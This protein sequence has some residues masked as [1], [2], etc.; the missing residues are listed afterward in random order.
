MLPGCDEPESSLPRRGKAAVRRHPEDAGPGLV[1]GMCA[2]PAHDRN[3]GLGGRRVSSAGS[4]PARPSPN[5]A[6]TGARSSLSCSPPRHRSPRRGPARRR[7]YPPRRGRLDTPGP[8]RPRRDHLRRRHRR[9][10]PAANT[11]RVQYETAKAVAQRLTT[12]GH[13]LGNRRC[14]TKGRERGWIGY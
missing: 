9:L 13:Q 3:L 4:G 7:P 12:G 8:I 5:T 1:P 14:E 6:P 11:W 2:S 10:T